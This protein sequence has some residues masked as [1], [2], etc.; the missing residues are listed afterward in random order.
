M[1]LVLLGLVLLFLICFFYNFKH[2]DYLKGPVA[3]PNDIA[4]I[5]V[6]GTIDLPH[7]H[8]DK[9]MMAYNKGQTNTGRECYITGWGRISGNNLHLVTD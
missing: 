3:F 4:V 8:I 6:Q 7:P 9:I 2:P 5:E 1:G